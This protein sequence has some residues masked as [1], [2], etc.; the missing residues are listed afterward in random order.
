MRLRVATFN[1]RNGMAWDGRH[2]WPFRRRATAAVLR[3]LDADVVGLQEAYGFQARS[4]RNQL[5]GYGVTGDGRSARRRGERCCV[6]WRRA[7]L[8]LISSETRWYGT[9]PARAG[10]KLPHASFPR[11]ATITTFA[12]TGGGPALTFV[13]THLDEH[14]EANRV[15]AAEQLVAWLDDGPTIVVGDLNAGPDS[16][17]VATLEA[18]GLRSALG[19]EAPGT[20]HDFTGRIDGRR[21]DHV[22]VSH[23]CTVAGAR[24]V[25]D[26]P[27]GCLASDHWPVVADVAL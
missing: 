16:R 3:A 20:S 6:V 21:L 13:N 25:T 26:R 10:T 23:H 12:P 5:E 27:G 19:P 4:L 1:I 17:V 2:A 15:A 14:L 18:A 8:D 24:V 11:V 22:L 7:A 9:E